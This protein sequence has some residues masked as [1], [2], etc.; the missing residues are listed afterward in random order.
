MNRP[1]QGLAEG[2][3]LLAVVALVVAV[4]SF[5]VHAGASE[6]KERGATTARGCS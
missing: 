3:V 4:V 2:P 5:G 1:I 6:V